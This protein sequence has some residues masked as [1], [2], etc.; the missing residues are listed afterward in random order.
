M[1]NAKEIP[2]G[3]GSTTYE[4]LEPGTYPARLVGVMTMGV[5]PQRPYQGQEKAPRLE[6]RL[7]YE[8]LDEFMK[9]EDGNEQEDRPRWFSEQMGFYNLETERATSTQRYYALDPKEEAGGDWEK[10]IGTPCVVTLVQNV[11]KSGKN[12]GRVRNDIDNVSAMRPKEAAKAPELRNPPQVFDFY[13][14][15]M[16]VFEKLPDWLKDSLKNAVDFKGSKL[17]EAIEFDGVVGGVRADV[18]AAEKKVAGKRKVVVEDS[19][20]QA[21]YQESDGDW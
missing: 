9:D 20:E 15:D 13:N 8:L 17:E 18:E 16:G 3:G 14:P 21:E 2:F 12:I 11:T 1:L 10:L 5:Q 19:S 6:M 4:P 7:T